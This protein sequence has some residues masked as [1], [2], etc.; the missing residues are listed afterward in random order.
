MQTLFQLYRTYD[1]AVQAVYQ[2]EQAGFAAHDVSL[3]GSNT[4]PRLPRNAQAIDKSPAGLGAVIGA[5]V[6]GG[7]GILAGLGAIM[8]PGIGPMV[9]AGWFAVA[10]TG[11]G[12]GAVAGSLVGFLIDF[13]L[14]NARAR[15]AAKGLQHGG[16]L[17]LVKAEGVRVVDAEAILKEDHR[18]D[19]QRFAA[20]SPLNEGTTIEGLV[21]RGAGDYSDE[22]RRIDR[23]MDRIENAG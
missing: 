6:G 21:G 23:D 14:G 1:E 8:I 12:L 2:L 16:T 18:A 20:E 17:V 9:A 5:T 15:L 10:L 22:L 7:V 19:A 4:D 3:V 13:G 11:A